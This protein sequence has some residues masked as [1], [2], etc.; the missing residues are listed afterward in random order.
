MGIVRINFLVELKENSS[1]GGD[2]MERLEYQVEKEELLNPIS[3]K[4][5]KKDASS[6]NTKI[7]EIAM[8]TARYLNK[9]EIKFA[10]EESDSMIE[11]FIEE[12]YL[13]D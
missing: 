7:E 13:E 3:G 6:K 12:A 2:N 1:L 5:I 9:L 4:V 10:V 8:M 11:F